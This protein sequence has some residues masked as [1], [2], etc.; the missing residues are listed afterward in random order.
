M[1]SRP[2]R[3]SNNN[4]VQSFGPPAAKKSMAKICNVPKIIG[5]EHG[6]SRRRALIAPTAAAASEAEAGMAWRCRARAGGIPGVL[7]DVPEE[8]P[9]HG[10]K[11]RPASSHH[12]HHRIGAGITA[13]CGDGENSCNCRV[14]RAEIGARQQ[15]LPIAAR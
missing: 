2:A 12:H 13:S 14:N 5:V 15:I 3:E 6:N 10:V 11:Y 7:D 4:A 1:A 8:K 9:P